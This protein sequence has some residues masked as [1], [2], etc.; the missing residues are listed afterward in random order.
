MC[1]QLRA[2]YLSLYGHPSLDTPNITRLAQR[3]VTFTRAYSQSPLDT[4]SHISSYTGRYVGTHGSDMDFSPIRLSERTIGDYMRNADLRSALI[5]KSC[6]RADF[7]TMR[8]LNLNPR[9]SAGIIASEAGF[10]SYDRLDG[11]HPGDANSP[12][13]FYPLKYNSYL[14]EKE[15]E[16]VNPWE[17]FSAKSDTKSNAFFYENSHMPLGVH[18][19]E[20]ETNYLVQRTVDFFREHGDKPWCL[21][22]SLTKPHWPYMAPAPFHN[23]Y[24]QEHVMA[25]NRSEAERENPHPF[26]A[27]AMENTSARNFS[28]NAKRNNVV[29]A[30]M[31]LVKQI[32]EQLGGLFR[33]MD[34]SD[35]FRDTMVIFTSDHGAYLG[36]HWLGEKELFHDPVVRV[37]LI[38]YD[39]RPQ[40]NGSRGIKCD[41]L[42]ELVDLVPTMLDAAGIGAMPIHVEGYSLTPIL[43][44]KKPAKWRTA[45]FSEY[46]YSGSSMAKK[47]NTHALDAKI[48]MMADEKWK[49]IHFKDYPAMLFDLINDP[50]ELK[51]LGRESGY[52]KAVHHCREQLLEWSLHH[53]SDTEPEESEATYKALEKLGIY[54]GYWSVGEIANDNKSAASPSPTPP[55]T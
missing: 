29:P 15:Y 41:E 25:P 45:A 44:G 55:T 38:V 31:G 32:D 11:L 4:P 5:G 34:R 22:L 1:S 6:V 14:K 48:T 20:S 46:N 23:M 21:H 2:D 27:H 3:S 7:A 39:P 43:H 54:N 37:P 9:T 33:M 13:N 28:D 8:L 16:A 36:D 53:T 51:D 24:N 42:V 12:L 26:Y 17:E 35:M 47:M 10:E 30:Y 40:A 19:L 52:E 18:E 49:Y 50:H